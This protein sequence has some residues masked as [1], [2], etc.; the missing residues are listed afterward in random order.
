[1]KRRLPLWHSSRVSWFGSLKYRNAF[2]K[3]SSKPQTAELNLTSNAF[4]GVNISTQSFKNLSDS[5]LQYSREMNIPKHPSSWSLRRF[6]CWFSF[7]SRCDHHLVIVFF[8]CQ[9][10]GESCLEGETLRKTDDPR[11]YRSI[12]FDSWTSYESGNLPWS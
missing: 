6:S 2:A 3:I 10:Y 5:I 9:I 4:S 7:R 11:G 1:M 12:R 8:F